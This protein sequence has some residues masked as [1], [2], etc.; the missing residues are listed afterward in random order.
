MG[1]LVPQF[2][3]LHHSTSKFEVYSTD[4]ATPPMT[5]TIDFANP[6]TFFC[7][8]FVAKERKVYMRSAS[9]KYLYEWDLLGKTL[10]FT[11]DSELND[12]W[13]NL[14]GNERRSCATSTTG[15]IYMHT[16]TN[17][18]GTSGKYSNTD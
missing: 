18:A 3:L 12:V 9:T 4:P 6:G 15:K 14:N 13:E 17:G 1:F 10:A 8:V 11:E 5:V 7:G 16:G 2:L